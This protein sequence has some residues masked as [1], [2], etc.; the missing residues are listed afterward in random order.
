[1][2]LAIF[3]A[4]LPFVLLIGFIGGRDAL[5]PSSDFLNKMTLPGLVGYLAVTNLL[6]MLFNLIPAFP[7]DGGRVL[8]AMR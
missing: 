4:L 2:N 1:M 8:R 3:V 7:V 5:F 6:I